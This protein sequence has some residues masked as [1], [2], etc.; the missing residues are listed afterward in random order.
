MRGPSYFKILVLIVGIF[1][2]DL[3][4]SQDGPISDSILTIRVDR[5]LT[6]IDSVIMMGISESA[7]PGGVLLVQHMDSILVKKPYGFHTYDS[8]K[9]V[10]V[11]DIYDLA[12]V[13]KVTA[14][15][16]AMMKLYDQGKID[17]DARVKKYVP[18]L[19]FSPQGKASIRSTLAHQAGWRSWIPY[20]QDMMKDGEYKSRF[21]Q[22]DSSANF[23]IKIRDS[24][25]LT[26][27]H[28]DYIKRQ[29]KKAEFDETKGYEYSG[30]FFYLIPEIVESI[31]GKTIDEFLQDEFYEALGAET[32]GYNPM[33]RFPL[34]RIVPTEVDTFFRMSPI[35][36][37]VHDEGAITM[38]GVSGNAGLFSNA[39]DLAKVWSILIN[40]GVQDTTKYLSPQVIDLFTTIQY[41]NNDNRRGLGFDKPMLVYEKESSS[42]AERA[43]FRSFGH[44]GYTGPIVWA[45]PE[46]DLLFI[47]L[48]NRV[49]PSRNQRKIYELGI[50]P[51]IHAY[52]YELIDLI[53][54]G[55]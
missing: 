42:V 28:Y 40:N 54:A 5:I 44:T 29:I 21:F 8:L 2:S 13:T 55:N 50:R 7:Y 31:S 17:L 32:I 20:Y 6:K 18:G 39:E 22:T 45:D 53:K 51:T 26:K 33:E 14:A 41:P 9:N 11:D 24:L 19:G 48:C 35:H 25:Y 52:C 23:P 43:S 1:L 4:N 16:L 30:L 12:S 47:F 46:E 3:A 10:Q 37:T 27:K 49:Y 15:T 38:G 36:G 34:E